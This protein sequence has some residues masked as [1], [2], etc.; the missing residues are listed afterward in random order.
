VSTQL[1]ACGAP[2]PD[3]VLSLLQWNPLLLQ[4]QIDDLK[5]SNV[6]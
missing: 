3:Q 2:V 1:R 6:G 4:K 5:A